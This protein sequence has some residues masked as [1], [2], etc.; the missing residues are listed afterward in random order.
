MNRVS[1]VSRKAVAA[2]VG[3]LMVVV[4]TQTG[5]AA[6]VRRVPQTYATI[7]AAIDAA[8]PGDSIDVAAGSSCVATLDRHVRLIGHGQPVIV[9]CADG[10]VLPAGERIGFFLPGTAGANPASGSTIQGFVFDGRGL[11]QTNLNPLS[12]GVFARFADNVQVQRNTFLGTIQAVTNVAGDGWLIAQNQIVDLTVFDC[13][14][15]LCCGGDGIALLIA[16]GANATA[17]GP[18]DPANRPERNVVIDN[19][20]SGT[21]PDGFDVFSMAGIFVFA[22]DDTLIA[23]NRLDLPDNPTA[24]AAGEGILISNSCC[25][26]PAVTPGARNTVVVGNDGR[27]SQF[28]V[29]VE[30]TGGANTS[31]LVLFGNSGTVEA[32]G[33]IVA[34]GGGHRLTRA[35]RGHRHLIF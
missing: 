31:G 32:E 14:G 3:G 25:G 8:S 6:A 19:Q 10:P 18:S 21:L 17:G 2:L 34:N 13:T 16:Q 27:A 23:R 7:Q 12:L 5:A 24:D 11:S 35:E 15:A 26:E 33:T 29:V 20:I 30:G 28:A 1:V 4:A 22:A 9:G